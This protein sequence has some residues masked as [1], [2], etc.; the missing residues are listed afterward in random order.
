MIFHWVANSIFVFMLLALLCDFLLRTFKVT[1]RR[2]RYF[3]RS[4]P[5]LK[6]PFDIFIFG[7]YGD[8]LFTNFNPLSC[9]L[10]VQSL[11]KDFLPLH[12]YTE[13]SSIER[14]IV[15]VYFAER[16]PPFL[17]QAFVTLVTLV[18]VGILG[19]KC[20]QF[21]HSL[22]TLRGILQTAKP[23]LRELTNVPLRARLRQLNAVILVSDEVSVPFAA[24]RRHLLLPA[25]LVNDLSQEEYEAVIAH[26]AEHLCWK[27]PSFKLLHMSLCSFFWWVP[28]SWWMKKL[29]EEQEEACDQGLYAFGI[30]P[31]S[32]AGALMKAVNYQKACKSRTASGAVCHLGGSKHL[33]K[34]LDTLLRKGP[35][36]ENRI[37]LSSI[38]GAFLCVIAFLSLWMC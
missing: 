12:F 14:L 18:T 24:N 36:L 5:L 23:C 26:E 17:L 16:I 34:R 25:S 21:I 38:A 1:N 2:L 32:L 27:D 37:P 10:Q 4:L 30:D 11:L 6:L 33:M 19:M 13:L 28:T 9:E 29:E 20:V 8:S 22:K 3:C 35:L 15:P 7:V 31:L